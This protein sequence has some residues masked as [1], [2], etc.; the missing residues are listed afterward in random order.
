MT[1]S[2][3]LILEDWEDAFNS[4]GEVDFDPKTNS[5]LKPV[6][7]AIPVTKV[8]HIVPTPNKENED[9]FQDQLNDDFGDFLSTKDTGNKVSIKK[10]KKSKRAKANQ[11]GKSLPGKT[12]AFDEAD[13]IGVKE[14]LEKEVLKTVKGKKGSSKPSLSAG[15]SSSANNV[16]DGLYDDPDDFF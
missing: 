8:T 4:E 7:V 14:N 13:A 15:K 12:D 1:N 5:N 6:V 2:N 3:D 16:G 11:Q 10:G 9:M